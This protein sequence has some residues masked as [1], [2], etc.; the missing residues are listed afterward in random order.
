ME[1]TSLC[2]PQATQ[3][4]SFREEELHTAKELPIFEFRVS[5]GN[6]KSGTEKPRMKDEERG[7]KNGK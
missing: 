3:N 5:N 7:M 1:N 2:F 6:S 4:G